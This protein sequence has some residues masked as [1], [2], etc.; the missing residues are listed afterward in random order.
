MGW[1]RSADRP[2][3]VVTRFPATA[4]TGVTQERTA[5]PSTWTVQAPQ[6][7][8]PHPNLVLV[9]PSCSRRTQSNGV[10]GSTSRDFISPFIQIEV[11]PIHALRN[12]GLP[13]Q[14]APAVDCLRPSPITL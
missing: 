13:T 5:L 3:I 9:K 11:C 7:A 14:T 8:S 12:S 4:V 2:S 10:T 1:D 6:S